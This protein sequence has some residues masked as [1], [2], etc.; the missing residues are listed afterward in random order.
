MRK[1]L[2]IKAEERGRPVAK[3]TLT[4]STTSA[5]AVEP[6]ALGL[7]VPSTNSR[8]VGEQPSAPKSKSTRTRPVITSTQTMPPP[9]TVPNKDT[10]RSR[11]PSCPRS[12]EDTGDQERKRLLSSISSTFSVKSV[13]PSSKPLIDR[14]PPIRLATSQTRSVS[15]TRPALTSTG[16]ARRIRRVV[17]I[18]QTNRPDL[19]AMAK[20]AATRSISQT[21]DQSS[22]GGKSTVNTGGVSFPTS[23]PRS[24]G[25]E[26]R[27]AQ[28]VPKPLP[29]PAAPSENR[30][31][32]VSAN[33]SEPSAP[34]IPIPKRETKPSLFRR[35]VSAD[36]RKDQK[37]EG[38]FAPRR[39]GLLQPTLSQLNKQKPPV[40]MVQ[41]RSRVV[42]QAGPK[43]SGT[44][45]IT[46]I[47]SSGP[48][49]K[50]VAPVAGES[51]Q[52]QIV[53][54]TNDQI[55]D[56]P[57][58]TG[59][60]GNAQ[61]VDDAMESKPE[62]DDPRVEIEPGPAPVQ[63][64]EGEA[65]AIEDKVIQNGPTM[66]QAEEEIRSREST[67][68]PQ[69]PSSSVINKETSKAEWQN[70]ELVSEVVPAAN[71]I[72]ITAKVVTTI[73]ESNKSSDPIPLVD[74]LM[75]G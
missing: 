61:I 63:K 48:V 64:S 42:S 49:A 50:P 41:S 69:T 70:I 56:S 47:I 8:R 40:S 53:E 52:I 46:K 72:S 20:K 73:P 54:G 1:Y 9:S 67:P 6:N 33:A 18:E 28:R 4:T 16:P 25:I 71:S 39:G 68:A 58:V 7:N 45:K 60:E 10:A 62:A 27:G 13:P 44:Q 37:A 66:S 75:T 11:S 65:L 34:A 15:V 36:E 30:E 23:D 43:R 2:E 14:Q 22:F 57:V 35:A 32:I 3:M 5:P 55:T 19:F 24:F 74:A 38:G 17:S 21:K 26:R 29:F 51:S 59:P 31:E 12:Q